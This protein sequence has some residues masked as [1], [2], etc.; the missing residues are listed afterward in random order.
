MKIKTDDLIKALEIVKPGVATKEVVEQADRFAFME[1]RVVTYNDDISIS[2][3]VPGL[4]ITGAIH[5][6][7]LYEILKRIKKEEVEMEIS[8]NEIRIESG[9]L[10]VGLTLQKEIRMPL[11][12]IEEEEEWNPVPKELM[13]YLHFAMGSTTNDTSRP[14]LSCVHVRQDG[15]VES[16]D[17]IRL[18]QCELGEELPVDSFLIPAK[19]IRPLL[20]LDMTEMAQG[21]GNWI[22]F[23]NSEETQFSARLMTGTFPNVD[24]LLNVEGIELDLPSSILDAID[25]AVIFSD[26]ELSDREEITV[27]LKKNRIVIKSKNTGGWVTEELNMKYSDDPFTFKIAPYSLQNIVKKNT[28]CVVSDKLIKFEGPGW[29]YVSALSAM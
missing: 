28:L 24:R 15:F 16:S 19:C 12:E 27:Q 1:G 2:H 11:E 25:K 21:S 20:A 13:E 29:K 10:K 4:D 8:D 9:R 7:E 23:R 26:D 5:A 17:N 6:K 3:P 18:V 14:V 22:H